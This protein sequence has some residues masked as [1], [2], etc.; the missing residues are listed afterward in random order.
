MSSLDA[1]SALLRKT[2]NKANWKKVCD[3]LDAWPSWNVDSALAAVEAEAARWDVDTNKHGGWPLPA[4]YTPLAWAKALMAGEV[5]QGLPAARLFQLH[6]VKVTDDGLEAML[7]A[8][9]LG[10]VTH[11]YLGGCRLGE[12]AL[13]LLTAHVD[14]LGA[15][16]HLVL[17]DNA[18]APDGLGALLATPLAERLELL[19]LTHTPLDDRAV[20]ALLTTPLPALRQLDLLFTGASAEAL[21]ELLH[22]DT[23]PA[24]TTLLVATQDRQRLSHE[25]AAAGEGHPHLLRALRPFP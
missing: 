10:S 17:T 4:R 16:T 24:L 8:G 21:T 18:L 19:D 5:A 14:Q 11:L 20:D 3:A 15:L 9:A 2:P 7:R 6:D 25:L 23:L 22:A 13:A 12:A 1:L